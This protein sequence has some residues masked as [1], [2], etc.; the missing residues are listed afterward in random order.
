MFNPVEEKRQG[1]PDW[2]GSDIAEDV[3]GECS[4]YG[5]VLH[6]HADKD[7]R[8]RGSVMTRS[9]QGLTYLL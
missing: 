7:S 6:C 4:K 8:V 9:L 2:D 3:S 5:Q 1:G